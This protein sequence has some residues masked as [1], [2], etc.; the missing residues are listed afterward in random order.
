MKTEA[1]GTTE[2]LQP[3]IS[4]IIPISL[5]LWASTN[6]LAL[7]KCGLSETALRAIILNAF[8]EVI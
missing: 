8:A 7:R 6:W 2:L 1:L 4:T 3:D 5:P